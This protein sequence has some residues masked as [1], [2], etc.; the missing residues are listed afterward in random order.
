[1]RF[2]N[3][4]V[5]AF[6]LFFQWPF[7]LV[8]WLTFRATLKIP[9]LGILLTPFLLLG[10]ALHMLGGAAIYTLRAE[11]I[12]KGT[13]ILYYLEQLRLDNSPSKL[14]QIKEHFLREEIPFEMFLKEQQRYGIWA[15]AV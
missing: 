6:L 7:R 2:W 8:Q 9:L 3:L 15:R 4:T 11:K 10:L 13:E 12:R 1:M 5:G 14:E